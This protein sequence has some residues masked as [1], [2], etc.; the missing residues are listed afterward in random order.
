MIGTFPASE[1]RILCRVLRPYGIDGADLYRAEGLDASL[2][3]KPRA[4]YPFD[5]V[6]AAWGR[7]ARLTGKPHIGLELARHWRPTD[8]HGLAVVFLASANLRR[9]LERL[10]RY[11]VVVNTPFALRLERHDD[12]LDLVCP[13]IHVDDDARRVIQDARAAVIVEMCRTGANGKLDPLRMEFAYPAPEDTSPHAELLRCQLAFDRPDWRLSF[14]ASDCDRPFLAHDREL[15]RRNDR[16][17]DSMMTRLHEDDLVSRVK[18]AMLQ[19]LPSGSPSEDAIAKAVSM[20]TRS[21]QRRL[22]EDGTSFTALLALL[23][24]ELAEQYVEDRDI[25]VTEIS[26]LLGFSDVSSFSRAFK[27]W[28]GRSPAA[29]RQRGAQQGDSAAGL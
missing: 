23:R 13:T 24:K 3:E 27:R 21:L 10:A 2:I 19:D 17:L 26:Y 6:A 4:R 8:F 22:A 1:A 15:A 12:H 11:H 14:R 20:S 18:L 7:A 28:T 9:A 25:P 29:R 5:R 16:V